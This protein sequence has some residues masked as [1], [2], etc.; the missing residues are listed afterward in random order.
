MHSRVPSRL[1]SFALALVVGVGVFVPSLAAT[2]AA[3]PP[4]EVTFPQEIDQTHFTSSFGDS[5]SGGR[6]HKGNDLIAPRMTEVYA[7]ADGTVDY[8]GI[9][10][11][12][13][14]NIKIDHGDGWRSVYLHL[15]N[16]NPGTDDG[17]APWTLTVAPGVEVGQSVEAGQLI[18]WVG[19]SGNAEGTTPHTHF[20]LRHDDRAI[21]PYD[22]LQDAFERAEAH[23]DLLAEL[24]AVDHSQFTVE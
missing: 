4:F 7:V 11:L 9:N 21:D 2:A 13:G 18:G 24:M 14:R 6:H 19:D 12:S 10:R 5:R 23:E 22:L 16:D 15:N 1:F 17:N 8:V 3:D 20:E